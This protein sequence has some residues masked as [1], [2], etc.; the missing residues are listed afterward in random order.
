MG[1]DLKTDVICLLDVPLMAEEL[2]AALV[3]LVYGPAHDDGRL[4]ELAGLSEH[5]LARGLRLLERGRLLKRDARGRLALVRVWED[6]DLAELR[7]PHV[8]RLQA[9]KTET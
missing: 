8:H 5:G 7:S 1:T 2:R 6:D 4:H 3:L 9:R